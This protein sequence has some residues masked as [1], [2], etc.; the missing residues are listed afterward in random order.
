LNACRFSGVG[1][2]DHSVVA[3]QPLRLPRCALAVFVCVA[4]LVGVTG[5]AHANHTP[6]EVMR[7]WLDPQVEAESAWVQGLRD[8]WLYRYSTAAADSASAGLDG[9][10]CADA[11]AGPGAD[12]RA[13]AAAG[14]DADPRAEAAA[15]PG[16]HAGADPFPG[17]LAG[18]LDETA[19][20]RAWDWRDPPANTHQSDRLWLRRVLPETEYPDKSLLLANLQC[21]ALAVFLDGRQIYVS[22]SCSPTLASVRPS[23]R[24]HLIPLASD[25]DGQTLQIVFHNNRPDR[26]PMDQP[27]FLHASQSQLMRRL[28]TD[29]WYKQTF[30]F[31]FLFVGLYALFAHRVR[32]RYGLSFSPWFAFMTITLGA[33][34]L[35][36]GNLM[37]MIAERAGLFYHAGLLAVLLFPIG[38]W[39]FVERSFGPG[40][41]KLIRRCW[42]LQI[43][44]CL[45]IWI[46]DVMGWTPFGAVGQVVGNAALALQLIVGVGEGWRHVTRGQGSTQLIAFGVLVFSAAGLLDVA[47]AFLPIT[48]GAELYPWGALVLIAVLAL[49][50]ERAA[51]EAQL[52]LRR[53]AEALQR[54]QQHLEQL[55][56]ERTAELRS[57]TAAAESAN[58]TKSE[59]L[60][61]MSHELRTPLNAIL[62]YAQLFQRDARLARDHQERADIIR[63]SG[64]HLLMLINDILDISRIEAGKLEIQPGET[65]LP[66]LVKGVVDM[67]RPRAQAKQ[68]ALQYEPSA[69]LPEVAVTDEKRVRQL[70][71]NLL[72]NAVKFTDSGRVRLT[73]ARETDTL[74]F[75]VTD[76]GI[77]IAPEH[78]ETIFEPFRQLPG[79]TL[80]EGTG[81]GL[82]IS[83]TIARKMGG[84][85]RVESAPGRG[86]LF[87]LELPY[88]AGVSGER[89]PALSAQEE[90]EPSDA[91]FLPPFLP[92][93]Y[94][95]LRAAA[96]IGDIQRVL[97]EAQRL[98]R[99]YPEHQGF[100]DRICRL[101]EEFDIPALQRLLAGTDE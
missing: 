17:A 91:S 7:L 52:Q 6:D 83:R 42:Q 80:Q 1:E 76:S 89:P 12:P 27:V 11:A 55:V 26:F 51:G 71:L 96:R 43:L 8:G 74:M 67:I 53:Q 13:D 99:R 98:G 90:R 85:V 60:A 95:A 59:F 65:R 48:L 15:G 73:A 50:Q 30:G 64:E 86:S 93:D 21:D 68:L 44:V 77:G 56:D 22:G 84:D 101:A 58:R 19:V 5:E 4:W 35:L 37:F 10:P 81:L 54:H 97:E 63:Q 2:D 45:A 9:D 62:G 82:A 41:H 40:W 33:S 25:S 75:C 28:L 34:Q 20:W 92:H 38:L 94:D 69:S 29:S 23:N 70:L 16:A 72:S 39:R 61:N 78:V 14:P 32:R 3:G 66:A 36:S 18:G 24:L 49:G 88:V 57:A 100:I 31:L 47:V 46:P 87:R 79:R